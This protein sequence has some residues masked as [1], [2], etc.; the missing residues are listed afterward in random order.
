MGHARSVDRIGP[1]TRSDAAAPMIELDRGP[2]QGGHQHR[3]AGPP[4]DADAPMDRIALC[5][6]DAA[7]KALLTSEALAAK[8]A[9]GC[10]V[11]TSASLADASEAGALDAKARGLTPDHPAYLIYTS[12]S[13]GTPK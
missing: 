3:I 11:F 4:F 1:R 9:V 5:L 12:G 7:A 2:A 10:P 8:T 13:T 6:A